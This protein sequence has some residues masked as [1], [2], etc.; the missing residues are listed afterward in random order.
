MKIKKIATLF[1][2]TVAVVGLAACSPGASSSTPSTDSNDK[3]DRSEKLIIYSNSVSNGRG[4]WLTSKAKE[5]G[6]NI[7]MVEVPGAELADRV[8]AEKNNGIADIVYGVNAVDSNKLKDEKV[9]AQY[10]PSWSDKVDATLADKDGYFNPVFIQPLVLIGK[11]GVDMPADWTELGSK[12]AGKY[13][14]YGLT[15]GTSRMILASILSR[16]LDEKG[17]LGVSAEGWKAAKEYIQNAYILQKGEN[18]IVKVLDEADPTVYGMM[19]GS[20]A[21]Q[22]QKEHN[23]EFG[24]MSPKVGVP[25]VTEQTMIL[26][27]SK[28]QAL[29]KEFLD[30]FG[31]AD[32][33][34]EY[35]AQFGS[36][37]ANQDAFKNLTPDAQKLLG[38]VHQQEIDWETV[39]K[40]LD[41][42]VEKVELEF[43]K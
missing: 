32:V 15:G 42:W 2:A 9:L 26:S 12:Y 16:Y 23:V 8:V 27:S 38:A 14:I 5:A 13:A 30:W 3:A 43:M 37:P 6:F 39:G 17:E 31:T 25:F 1:A 24:I 28:K 33:L 22:G 29:A 41:Q 36:I 19:W 35:N 11:P 34:T 10:K 18:A 21:L 40:Y 7:E 20:G 4:E